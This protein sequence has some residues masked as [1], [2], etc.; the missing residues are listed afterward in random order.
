MTSSTDTTQFKAQSNQENHIDPLLPH[1]VYVLLDP[2]NGNKPFYVGKGTGNRVKQHVVEVKYL[3]RKEQ[4]EEGGAINSE[5]QK[6]IDNILKSNVNMQPLEVILA[7]FETAEEAFAVEAIYI[8]QVFGYDT[9][10]NIA[11]GHGAQFMRTKE[12]FEVICAEAKDQ[13]SIERVDGI[14][15]NRIRGIRDGL[16]RDKKIQGLTKAGAYDHMSDLQQALTKAGISWRDYTHP[17]DNSFHPGESN[18]YLSLII[19]IGGLDLNVQFTKRLILSINVIFTKRTELSAELKTI[20][21]KSRDHS[22]ALGE[23]KNKGRYAWFIQE[24][25]IKKQ[26]NK[27]GF[28]GLLHWL[29]DLQ[30]HLK[31]TQ[32]TKN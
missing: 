28:T 7:R 3:L 10:T 19:E 29:N 6:R 16:F 1:Y 2:S 32:T 5:K 11:S 20:N 26:I 24:N 21:H 27:D 13:E 9:L 18:G 23:K 14:D 30:K 31:P 15:Q 22:Y 17:G 25:K 4:R 12:Q 8:H